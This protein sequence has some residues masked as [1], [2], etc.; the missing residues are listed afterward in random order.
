LGSVQS[1][2]TINAGASLRLTDGINIVG[3]TAIL[4]GTGSSFNGALQAAENATATWSGPVI[5]G[6]SATRIG[7]M[8]GGTLVISGPISGST[9]FQSLSIGAGA[10]GSATVVLSAP[11]GSSNYTGTTSI[12]RGTLKLGAEHTLPA[13]TTLDVDSANAA[14]DAIL[15]LNGHNQLLAG[16]QR[17]NALGGAGKSIITN[18]HSQRSVLS[19]HSSADTTYSGILAG[20]LSL[21]KSNT[22]TLTLNA[23]NTYTGD[24]TVAGG[25]LRINVPTL[26]D[27]S[28]I[29][30]AS[31][32][33]L[34]LNFT[35]TD[36]IRSLALGGTTMPPGTYN[37]GNQPAYFSGSGSLVVPM[38]FGSWI[39][40]HP[41]WSEQDASPTAD[42]DRDGLANLIEYAFGIPADASQPSPL[43]TI[44]HPLGIQLLF[45]RLPDRTDLTLTVEA[46]DAVSQWTP[47]ARS[48]AGSSFTALIPGV[49][50][51]ETVLSASLIEVSITDTSASTGKRFLRIAVTR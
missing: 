46:S 7:A 36:Q 12:V 17:S 29:S 41:E 27:T 25:I 28:H 31:G 5:L 13:T 10:G 19:I 1:T 24:T 9:A 37:S 44:P 26:A 6:D 49:S 34:N 2:G 47:I 4:S 8:P 33:N 40:L 38:H 48:V 30:I 15:D 16:L 21:A 50:C 3:K 43:E 32:A 35:G 20:N 22:G 18:T 39:H 11:Q 23:S 45:D 14:E 42:P 51:S